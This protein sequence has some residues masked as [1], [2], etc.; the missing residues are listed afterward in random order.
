MLP[1]GLGG[2]WGECT[3]LGAGGAFTLTC[4]FRV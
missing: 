2:I 1:K 4:C 3:P